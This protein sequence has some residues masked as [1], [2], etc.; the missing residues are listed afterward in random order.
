MLKQNS[1]S[2]VITT[3]IIIAISFFMIALLLVFAVNI[4]MPYIWYEK[5][6]GYSLKYIFIMEEY[7]SLTSVEKNNL[8]DELKSGG[9]DEDNITIVATETLQDYGMPIFLNIS[10]KY[11]MKLPKL[12]S[13]RMTAVFQSNQVEMNVRRQSVSKR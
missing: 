7:G 10:Y 9:F 8:L 13:G 5:L 12:L 11:P 3:P 2:A 1:G 4:L 6:S